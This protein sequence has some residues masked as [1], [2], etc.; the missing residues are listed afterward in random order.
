MRG[1]FPKYKLKISISLFVRK[2]ESIYI[3]QKLDAVSWSQK[4]KAIE[5]KRRLMKRLPI[6][7][8]LSIEISKLRVAEFKVNKKVH[9]EIF[10][11]VIMLN[12]YW[13]RKGYYNLT[14]TK[15]VSWHCRN[16]FHIVKRKRKILQN[17][18]AVDFSNKFIKNSFK[19]NSTSDKANPKSIFSFKGFKCMNSLKK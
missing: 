15:A 8:V 2:T 19:S 12:L 5:P 16:L 14:H 1:Y 10:C 18:N 6:E 17:F 9:P 13:T 7:N 4:E 11:F 3:L